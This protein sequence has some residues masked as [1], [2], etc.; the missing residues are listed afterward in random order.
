MIDLVKQDV[1]LEDTVLQLCTIE[2]ACTLL[3][4]AMKEDDFDVVTDV[5]YDVASSSS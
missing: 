2:Y 3:E 5:N 1:N 4:V